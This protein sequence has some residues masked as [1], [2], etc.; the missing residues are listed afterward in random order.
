[1]QEPKPSVLFIC[2]SNAG[3]SQMAEALMRKRVGDAASIHSAGTKPKGEVNQESAES[4]ERAG[5]T[6]EGALSQPIDDHLLRT[7]DRVIILG[8]DAQ[9]EPLHDMLA[10]IE[11]WDTVEPSEQGI[12][13]DKRMDM[14][15]DD[16]AQRVDELARELGL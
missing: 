4:V 6:M 8:N 7:V 3:K 11:R 9:V 1:M 5:A 14:I 10:T 12:D 16:I 15:R 13:G 2:V